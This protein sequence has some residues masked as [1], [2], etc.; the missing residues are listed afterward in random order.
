MTLANFSSF[1]FS[2]LISCKE[3]VAIVKDFLP[4]CPYIQYIV[5]CMIKHDEMQEHLVYQM[6]LHFIIPTS[7]RSWLP[8]D[9][10]DCERWKRFSHKSQ[11]SLNSLNEVWERHR[12]RGQ[13]L[14]N[15][16]YS[17]LNTKYSAL[18]TKHSAQ[19]KTQFIH[20]TSQHGHRTGHKSVDHGNGKEGRPS[21]V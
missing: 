2:F 11:R 14:Q 5:Y 7:W 13:R 19:Q 16:K 8:V 12:M 15:T 21:D 4:P 18:N 3:Y 10:T 17:A 20:W 9:V 1:D 6:F